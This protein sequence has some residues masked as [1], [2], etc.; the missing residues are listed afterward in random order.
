MISIRRSLCL[1]AMSALPFSA[2]VGIAYA[3]GASAG[4]DRLQINTDTNL[5]D[6]DNFLVDARVARVD[7]DGD[8]TGLR[9][10][11]TSSDVQDLEDV[12]TDTRAVSND[13]GH[14][15]TSSRAILGFD[16][17]RNP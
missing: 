7:D 1:A 11:T 15:A 6:R 4:Q 14:D 16:D 12:H 13:E 9:S 17:V 5:T 10:R 8:A 3:E 2:G